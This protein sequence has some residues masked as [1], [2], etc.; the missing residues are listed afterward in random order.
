MACAVYPGQTQDDY[1]RIK[2][3]IDNEYKLLQS[4]SVE[5]KKKE[6]YYKFIFDHVQTT[7][8]KTYDLDGGFI[9]IFSTGKYNCLTATLLYS[10]LLEK[11]HIDYIIKYMPNHVYLMVNDQAT[12]YIFETTDPINGFMAISQR[13]QSQAIKKMRLLHYMSVD[14]GNAQN[15][16]GLFDKYFIKLNNTGIKG[17]IGYQY[18]NLAS[19]SI[20][21]EDY[22]TAM[23]LYNKALLLT[24]MDELRFVTIN[25]LIA[26]YTKAPSTS[27][28]KAEYL[29]E[30][31]NYSEDPDRNAQFASDFSNIIYNCLFNP[32]P[33]PDS[34]KPIFDY[35]S[36]NITQPELLEGI[37]KQYIQSNI[38]YLAQTNHS[39]DTIFK[40]LYLTFE[41]DRKN[42]TLKNMLEHFLLSDPDLNLE[43]FGSDFDMDTFLKKY[44]ALMELKMFR[45]AVCN[46]LIESAGRAFQFG[47][48]EK[49]EKL[50]HDFEESALFDKENVYFCNPAPTYCDACRAYFRKGNKVKAREMAKKGLSYNPNDI[51]LQDLL[52]ELK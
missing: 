34:L 29:L 10:F 13:S 15:E 4:K 36:E 48:I 1:I 9:D 5:F 25:L 7:F 18:V 43:G 16:T 26:A 31:Y 41:A 46:E 32:F 19:I 42:E 2:S 51:E 20:S 27:R 12:P 24:P 14:N 47:L 52:K 40:L 8:L 44:P 35:L 17:L 28:K 22:H 11:L 37:K 23:N 33:K 38:A 39:N 30:I 50:L 49:G 3:S 21:A 45:K 6:K